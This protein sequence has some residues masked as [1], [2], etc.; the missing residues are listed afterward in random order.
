MAATR[1]TLRSCRHDQYEEEPIMGL[2]V[3]FD[4]VTVRRGEVEVLKR[5][6]VSIP[7]QCVCA[8][9]G[10]SGAGKTTF[11]KALLGLLPVTA[12]SI[13]TEHGVLSDPSAL[14]AHRRVTAAVFQDHALID[15]LTA[16]EN[17][18]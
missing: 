11:I 5:L 10:R 16:I 15:R 8:V 3:G 9:L 13:F 7:R 12:G 17:V 2:A 1:R 6:S 18:K 14:A 4:R